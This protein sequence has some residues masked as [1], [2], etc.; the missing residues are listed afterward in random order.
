[1]TS[2]GVLFDLDGTL[3]DTAPDMA[4]AL[5]DLR[6]RHALQALPYEQLRPLVS[7]GSRA[8]I[9]HGFGADDEARTL[10]LIPDFLA[11]YAGRIARDSALFGEMDQVLALLEGSGVP[12]GV[13]TNKPGYLSEALLQALRLRERSRSL[14]CGDT[15]AERKPHPLP[16]THAARELGV[17]P[18]RC[19]YVGDAERDIR[20]GRAAGMTTVAAAYGYILPDDNATDWGADHVVHSVGELLALLHAWLPQDRLTAQP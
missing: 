1:M 19:L 2:V 11:C 20:A 3:V 9:E 16:M 10:A 5:N 7:H 6:G 18:E 14:V 4:G 13:V 12:W 17:P 8:L 15:L